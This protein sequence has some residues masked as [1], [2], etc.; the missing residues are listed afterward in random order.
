MRRTPLKLLVVA[1]L[2]IAP[3]AHAD[4]NII[5]F[6][7]YAWEDGGFLPSNAFDELNIVGITDSAD[8]IFGVDLGT[9][10]LTV[11]ATDLISTG[12]VP[13]GGGSYAVSY[14]GGT[15]QIWQDPAMN[16]VFGI[17]PPN[18]T[19]PSTFVDGTLLLGGTFDSFVLF[20]NT[21]TGSGTYQGT[22]TWN[23]GTALGTVLGIQNDGFTFGG[24]LNPSGGSVIEG[25]DLQ[26]DG[27]IEISVIIAVEKTTWGEIKN[28]YR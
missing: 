23:A 27:V 15:L 14:N 28:L 13:L 7:G 8:A 19:A 6:Q 26:V 1:I 22:V 17:N 24:V 5:D 21:G 20:F 10:E 18:G 4:T 16:H 9:D 12:Q 11:Y 2:G 25:Y 3:V